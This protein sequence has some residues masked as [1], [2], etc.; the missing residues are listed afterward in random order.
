MGFIQRFCPG[1]SVLRARAVS[2][3]GRRDG[4]SAHS[5]PGKYPASGDRARRCRGA[6]EQQLL[7]R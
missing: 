5:A 7:T 1:S 4:A 2:A 3:E 6:H